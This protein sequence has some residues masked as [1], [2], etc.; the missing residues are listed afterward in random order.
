MLCGV[1]RI[2]RDTR[3]KRGDMKRLI[4]LREICTIFSICV[5][6]AIAA[7]AQT[8]T[9]LVDF[10]VTNGANPQSSLVQGTDGNF[11]GTT[12]GGGAYGIPTCTSGIGLV[13]C[14]TIFKMTPGGML[15]T[16]YSFC[17]QTNC[18]DGADP[19]AELVQ[20]ADGNF[21]GTTAAAGTDGCGT[22]FKI[23]PAGALTTLHSFAS[24]TVRTPSA[25]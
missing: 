22:V 18:P 2:S 8:L 11:Y 24:P 3:P 25:G 6:T 5:S 16:L 20:G 1:P 4:V 9:T 14:G 21:Y 23:T 17:A 13:G 12:S 7:P 10:A 15:S 19:I